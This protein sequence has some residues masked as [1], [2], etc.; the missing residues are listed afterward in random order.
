M[1]GRE[2]RLDQVSTFL[3]AVY[4]VSGSYHVDG[5][6]LTL[7]AELAETR[8]MKAVWSQTFKGSISQIRNASQTLQNVVTYNAVIDV[9]NAELKLRPGMTANVTVIYDQR[10]KALAVP[11]TAPGYLRKYSG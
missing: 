10:E 9:D 4:V 3:R 2:V 1:E 7:K 8:S 11:N 6:H 5:D